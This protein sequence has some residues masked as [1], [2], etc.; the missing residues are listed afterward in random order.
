MKLFL[1]TNLQGHDWDTNQGFVIRAGDDQIARA[2][3]NEESAD[4]GK[5]WGDPLK[6]SCVEIPIEGVPQIILTDF[7]AG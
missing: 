2:M 7:S 6:A 5:I 4:E 1:L 3:A